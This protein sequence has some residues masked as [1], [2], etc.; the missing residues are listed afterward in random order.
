MD[1]RLRLPA[2][3]IRRGLGISVDEG[4]FVAVHIQL[5][6]GIFLSGLALYLNANHLEI[7]LL[8]AIPA[9]LTTLGFLSASLISRWGKRKLLTYLTA[10]IGRGLSISLP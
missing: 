7:S 5:S 2:S 3:K 6:G 4:S 1:N 9:L 8:S 10:G